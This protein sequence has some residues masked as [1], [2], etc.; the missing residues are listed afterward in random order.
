MYGATKIV[1]K[2]AELEAVLIVCPILIRAKVRRSL[3]IEYRKLE[4]LRRKAR[5]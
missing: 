5:L 3:R 2:I 1:N 4:F